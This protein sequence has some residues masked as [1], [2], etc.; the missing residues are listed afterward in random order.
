VPV[1]NGSAKKRLVS[2]K[3]KYKHHIKI[4]T[5]GSK[6]EDKVGYSVICNQQTI[7]KRIRPQNTIFSTEQGAILSAIYAT[8]GDPG[9]KV[10]ATDSLRTLLA[11]SDK[12]FTKNP[13]TRLIRKLL[14]QDSRRR[15]NYTTVGL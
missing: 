1:A 14:Y 2:W 9:I 10:I 5:D 3:N 13:K 4:Y 15:Q 6:K 11:A 8:M 7:K 12:K